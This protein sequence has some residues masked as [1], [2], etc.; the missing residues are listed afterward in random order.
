MLIDVILYDTIDS[1]WDRLDKIMVSVTGLFVQ[2]YH[3]LFRLF[4]PMVGLFV[5]NTSANGSGYE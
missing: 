4:I 2:L 1:I 5:S 3:G